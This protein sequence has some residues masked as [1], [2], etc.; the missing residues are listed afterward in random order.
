MVKETTSKDTQ[1]GGS[2]VYLTIYGVPT[3]LVR[4]DK[5]IEDRMTESLKKILG[6]TELTSEFTWTASVSDPRQSTAVVRG[7]RAFTEQS[8]YLVS[9][10]G[11]GDILLDVNVLSTDV[12]LTEPVS[13]YSL[14]GKTTGEK[15]MILQILR[16][17]KKTKV[18]NDFTV[19]AVSVRVG[20]RLC[21]AAVVYGSKSSFIPKAGNYVIQELDSL[22]NISEICLDTPMNTF[23]YSAGIIARDKAAQKHYDFLR[24]Y[25]KHYVGR[26]YDDNT[27]ET[28]YVMTKKLDNF[29]TYGL[30]VLQNI[31]KNNQ[32]SGPSKKG[33]GAQ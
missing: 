1:R 11:G 16:Q 10:V 31:R 14:P 12:N 19:H 30:S 26:L 17:E 33:S 22:D 28:V 23:M 15:R 8:Y 25:T 21:S 29:A 13:Y 18:R 32:K 6:N 7:R 3:H 9:L 20:K 24:N 27:R 5:T 4:D 2:N